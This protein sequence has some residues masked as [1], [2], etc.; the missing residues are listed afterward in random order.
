MVL[1]RGLRCARSSREWQ[2]FFVNGRPIR[3]GLLAVMLERPYAGRLPL[4]RHPLAVIHD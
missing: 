1:S 4:N 2:M 3:S